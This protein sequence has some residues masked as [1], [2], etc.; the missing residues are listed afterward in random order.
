[1]KWREYVMHTA[2]SGISEVAMFSRVL[3]TEQATLPV[4]AAQAI[5]TFGFPQADKDRMA[6]LPA[7]AREGVLTATEQAE[8]NDYEK[9]GHMVALMKSKARRSLKGNGP[10]NGF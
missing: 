1:M 5:L 9:V 8:I 6:E 2:Q 4:A 7:K 3:E 10:T